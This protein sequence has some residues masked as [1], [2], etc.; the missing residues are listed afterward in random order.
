M[1]TKRIEGRRVE[2]APFLGSFSLR[3]GALGPNLPLGTGTSLKKS[4]I[5]LLR[6]LFRTTRVIAH[7]LFSPKKLCAL[8]IMIS[9]EFV[10]VLEKQTNL[11]LY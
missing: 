2:Y 4:D 3:K 5:P 6:A 8:D 11:H 7:I 10:S 1:G 9:V